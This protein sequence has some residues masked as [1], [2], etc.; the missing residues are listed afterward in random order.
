MGRTWLVF[1]NEVRLHFRGPATWFIY[2]AWQGALAYHLGSAT[3]SANGLPWTFTRSM[4]PI[5]SSLLVVLFVAAAARDRSERSQELIDALPH[6]THHP[7][8]G[9]WLAGWAAFA[10]LGLEILLVQAVLLGQ[11]GLGTLWFRDAP[12]LAV[13][14]LGPLLLAAGWG[15]GI[16]VLLRGSRLAYP[17]AAAVWIALVEPPPVAAIRQAAPRLLGWIPDTLDWLS[18]PLTVA[19]PVFSVSD[20]WGTAP[21]G[22]LVLLHH[23]AFAALGVALA[24]G[25]VLLCARGRENRAYAR[26][27]ALVLVLTLLGASGTAGLVLAGAG[28]N[29]AAYRDHANTQVGGTAPQGGTPA[30]PQGLSLDRYRL[31]GTLHGDGLLDLQATCWVRNGGREA[32]SAVPLALDQHLTVDAARAGAGWALRREGDALDILLDR[33]L[34]PGEERAVTIAYGGRIEE[35][36]PHLNWG[37]DRLAVVTPREVWLPAVFAWYPRVRGADQPFQRIVMGSPDYGQA[38]LMYCGYG[39]PGAWFDV[40]M[41]VPPGLR[42]GMSLPQVSQ[43]RDGSGERVEGHGWSPAGLSVLGSPWLDRV[44]APGLHVFCALP[45]RPLAERFLPVLGAAVESFR[46]W[47]PAGFPD[48]LSVLV[49]PRYWGLHPGGVILMDEASLAGAAR[50]LVRGGTGAYASDAPATTALRHV[51]PAWWPPLPLFWGPESRLAGQVRA[52]AA[53]FVARHFLEEAAARGWASGAVLDDPD[54]FVGLMRNFLQVGVELGPGQVGASAAPAVAE[55]NRQV[56]GMVERL[57]EVEAAR[58]EEAVKAILTRMR[59]LVLAERAGRGPLD[60]ATVEA[61]LR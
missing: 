17:L 15:T 52:A 10:P 45:D 21:E 31:A 32:V 19:R 42:L 26:A 16:W 2:A 40:E 13:E 25:A 27:A 44:T 48:P 29:L 53:T 12:Y 37:F 20:L 4:W 59:E 1:R 39:Q 38:Y 5:F 46:K 36:W 58:G 30:G 14:Y 35:W 43:E 22:T 60:A 28:R 54:F 3:T 55:W 24:V 11:A 57:G 33:P 7:V 56:W 50:T 23:L 47:V 61:L 6:R 9:R 51:V 34:A 8:V 18:G 49:L 41:A